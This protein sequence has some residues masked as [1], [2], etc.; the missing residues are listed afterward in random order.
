MRDTFR[1]L[2]LILLD[3]TILSPPTMAYP[4]LPGEAQIIFTSDRGGDYD[5]YLLN[6][7]GLRNL[8][9]HPA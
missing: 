1:A 4:S 2:I 5:I 6:A 9:R 8:T 7:H 3:I